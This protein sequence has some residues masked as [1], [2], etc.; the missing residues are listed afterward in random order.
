MSVVIGLKMSSSSSSSSPDA[1]EKKKKVAERKEKQKALVKKMMEIDEIDNEEE[2]EVMEAKRRAIRQKQADLDTKIDASMEDLL[3]LKKDT[4]DL[5]RDENNAV[6]EEI[7]YTREA[8]ADLKVTNKLGRSLLT[9]AMRLDDSSKRLNYKDFVIRLKGL[10]NAAAGNNGNADEDEEE[11]E[12]E[13]AAASSSA[14]AARKRKRNAA[15]AK[16]EPQFSWSRLGKDVG[17]LFKSAPHATMMLGP[18]GKPSKVRKVTEKVAREKIGNV[19]LAKPEDIVQEV[20]EE[21]DKEFNEAT[22]KRIDVQ[23][24]LILEKSKKSQSLPLLPLL[25]DAEDQVQTVENFFDYA[26]LIKEKAVAQKVE[27]ETKGGSG[28]PMIIAAPKEKLQELEVKQHVLSLN[29][30]E[31]K[32]L[33]ELCKDGSYGYDGEEEDGVTA[34]QGKGKSSSSGSGNGN[35]HKQRRNSVLHRTDELYTLEDP[36]K[37]AELLKRRED[38]QQARGTRLKKEKRQS[39]LGFSKKNPSPVKAKASKGAKS[40][41]SRVSASASPLAAQ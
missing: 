16:E 3:D 33:A 27:K 25:F 30:K 37:Q 17:A 22:F 18:L 10:F 11:A 40:S 35:G 7:I 41:S 2:N 9:K 36:F 19:A 13:E 12:E 31:L 5:I 1:A 28:L 26:F 8:I 15:A 29:M 23:M 34:S 24:N 4:W 39:Q 38:E 6:T 20:D 21:E 14:A 32:E